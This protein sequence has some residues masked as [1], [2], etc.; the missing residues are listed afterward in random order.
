[1]VLT[2][3]ISGN[4]GIILHKKNVIKKKIR[5]STLPTYSFLTLVLLNP[6]I[7]CLCNNLDPDQLASEEANDLY[8]HCL[9][10][11]M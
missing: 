10:L 3:Y 8:L 7:P 11:S 6:D 2:S 5:I 1:M 9:P 4:Y